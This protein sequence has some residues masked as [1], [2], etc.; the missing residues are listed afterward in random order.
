M[1]NAK[2]ILKGI[3]LFIMSYIAA[4][5]IWIFLDALWILLVHTTGGTHY[6]GTN[7]AGDIPG[8]G[9]WILITAVALFFY[10]RNEGKKAREHLDSV[11]PK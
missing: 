6:H 7:Q 4:L 2:R 8:V 11:L 1:D 10:W 5:I 9:L 3:G